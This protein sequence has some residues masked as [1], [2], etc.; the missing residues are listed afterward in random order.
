MIEG[1]MVGLL[2]AIAGRAAWSGSEL[3]S[4]IVISLISLPADVYSISARAFKTAFARHVRW[5]HWLRFVLSII[6]TIYPARA[7]SRI[8]P[9]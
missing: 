2:G 3:A 9:G 7:A 5:R 4:R 8:Q 1:A 6:A